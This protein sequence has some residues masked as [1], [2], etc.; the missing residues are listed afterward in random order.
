VDQRQIYL[1]GL[2]FYATGLWPFFG[3]DVAARIQ[4]PGALQGLVVGL[5]FYLL[6]IPEAPYLFLALLSFSGLC[7]FAW[8][9]S[10]RL[11]EFPQWII[12][13][14]LLTAPWTLNWSTNIDNDSYALFGA[15]LFFIGFL[16]S[17]PKLRGDILSLPLANFLMGFGFLWNFQF[18]M[19]Y[20]ILAPYLVYS[21]YRQVKAPTAP[22]LS[23]AAFM[24]LGAFSSGLF[25][26]PTFVKYGPLQGMGGSGNAIAF[27]GENLKDF[28]IVLARFLSLASC[29][30]PR[31]LGANSID[32]LSFLRDNWWIAPFAL[33]AG[34]LGILQALV[35]FFSGFRSQNPQKGWK[36]VRNLTF[37]TFLLIYGSFLFAIKTPA[38]HTY[39]IALPIAMLYGFYVF[40]PWVKH[41]WFLN[42]VKILLV[43]NI[44]FHAGLALHN[45]PTKSLY[46]G[47]DIFARAI[48]EKNYHLLGERRPDTLY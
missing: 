31:F 40:S 3:P 14:W 42:T 46:K 19:S 18:H 34:I 6:P 38:A 13:A 7:F 16:E 30:I 47:R 41:P 36:A 32:R 5:P 26:I 10:K 27:N 23:N 48:Q 24:A 11:P 45:F 1:L 29:E 17:T 28:F 12:W 15:F 44:L 39:Y 22:T 9:C 25:I 35:L 8:Y 33:T 4:L 43:C 2:K 21:L 37:L 20:V